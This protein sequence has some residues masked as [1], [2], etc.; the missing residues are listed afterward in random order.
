MLL[1]VLPSIV[2]RGAR[3][4]FVGTGEPDLE[5]ALQEAAWRWPGRVATRIAFDPGLARRVFAGAD[6]L[7]VPSRDEPCGL[8]QLYAMR[9][10]AI[11]IV[12]PVGGLCDTVEPVD[13]AHAKGTGVVAAAPDE[14]SV[15]LA[16][17]EALALSRDSVG[18]AS[19]TARGMARDSSWDKSAHRYLS[20]YNELTA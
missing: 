12:T 4:A 16:C 19:V 7:A 1:A 11:P 17:E 8:T 18:M 5:R 2:E 9:Y 10:G 14:W 3:V 15:L 13:V 6:F 20:L